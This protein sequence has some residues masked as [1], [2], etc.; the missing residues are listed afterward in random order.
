MPLF[1]FHF[2]LTA[3]LAAP[4]REKSKEEIVCVNYFKLWVRVD[5][6]HCSVTCQSSNRGSYFIMC[7]FVSDGCIK[8][9]STAKL[10]SV[11]TSGNNLDSDWPEDSK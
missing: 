4:H 1:V 10:F 2:V 8:N 3:E 7:S 9:S 6:S 11:G 5:S